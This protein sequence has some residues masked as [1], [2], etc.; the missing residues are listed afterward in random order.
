MAIIKR[1]REPIIRVAVHGN[2]CDVIAIIFTQ[3]R[4]VNFDGSGYSTAELLQ[5]LIFI[6]KEN[7]VRTLNVQ[8]ISRLR[9]SIGVA[10]LISPAPHRKRRNE[11]VLL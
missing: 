2:Y 8:S 1:S 10:Q 11:G 3:P 9:N 5:Q 6:S 7:F 4:Q